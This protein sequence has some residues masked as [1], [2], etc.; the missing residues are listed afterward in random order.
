MATLNLISALQ[1]ELVSM[2]NEARKRH[3]DV[4]E[5]SEKLIVILRSVKEFNDLCKGLLHKSS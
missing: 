3:Q 5:A 2:S 1:N 4:K